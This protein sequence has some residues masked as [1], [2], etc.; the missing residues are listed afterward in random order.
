MWEK[1]MFSDGNAFCLF[2]NHMYVR[3]FPGEEFKSECLKLVVKHL[4]K[5][6]AVWLIVSIAIAEGTVGPYI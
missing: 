3:R 6:W 4:L 5:V 1:M 2:G